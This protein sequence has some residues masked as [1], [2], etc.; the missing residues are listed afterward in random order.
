LSAEE[1]GIGLV[2]QEGALFPH[3]DV[4]ENVAFG[5]RVAKLPAAERAVRVDEM[6]TLVGLA[7]FGTRRTAR[8]SGGERQRVALARALAPRPRVLLLDEPLASL[9]RNLREELRTAVRR[10]HDALGLTT[11]FVTH[12]REEALAIADRLVV[13]RAGRV[14]EEGAPRDIFQQPA[15]AFTARLLGAANVVEHAGG[16]LLVPPNAITVERDEA[17][18]ATVVAVRFGGFHEEIDLRTDDG[19]MLLARVRAGSAPP[20]GARVRIQLDESRIRRLTA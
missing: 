6:L 1:R 16:R 3:L 4:A 2:F 13:M 14:V 5:L 8:L 11:V 9:D 19:T 12:D 17:G 10:L 15:T 20:M 7:G 18:K